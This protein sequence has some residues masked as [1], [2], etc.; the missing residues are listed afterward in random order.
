MRKTKQKRIGGRGYVYHV[1]QFGAREGGHVLVRLLKILGGS[2]GEALQG[3]TDFDMGVVGKVIANLA[4][5]VDEKDLDYLVDTF[6]K[7]T[8]V[9]IEGK[10]VP[11]TAEGVL[12]VHF[13][14]EYT[15]LSQWLAFA[16]EANFGDFFGAAGI[17]KAKASDLP[18]SA[19]SSADGSSPSISPNT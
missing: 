1:T 18:V 7:T 6:A 11:L 10:P 13:A 5:T 15:E 16:V 19:V 2:V 17:L 14:G 4:T 9:E 3:A 8:S 12:D